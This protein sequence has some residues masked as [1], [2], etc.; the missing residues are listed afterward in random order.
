MPLLDTPDGA[1]NRAFGWSA[2]R[3]EASVAAG[4]GISGADWDG[5]DFARM[6]EEARLFKRVG[7]QALADPAGFI[8]DVVDGLFG[9]RADRAG[10]RYDLAPWVPDGWPRLALRRLRCHRSLVDLELRP[11]AEWCTVRLSLEFGPAIPV[12]LSV[13]NTPPVAR[14]TVDEIA[15]AGDLAVFTLAGEHEAVFYYGDPG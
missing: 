4:P 3:A 10:G 13:R 6:V 2:G 1:L 7:A 8:R 15:L 14:I 5:A 11:R 9:V 12:S